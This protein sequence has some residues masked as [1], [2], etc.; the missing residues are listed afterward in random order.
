MCG[1]LLAV[2]GAEAIQ[3]AL[4]NVIKARS[5][6]SSRHDNAD[7]AEGY[8]EN[9]NQNV[10]REHVTLAGILADTVK[11]RRSRPPVFHIDT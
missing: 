10:K 11:S 2:L 8:G 7:C 4:R 1:V 9:S 5:F 6:A 3:D